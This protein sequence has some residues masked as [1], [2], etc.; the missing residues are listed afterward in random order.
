M[1]AEEIKNAISENP[2]LKKEVL[3][4]FSDTHVIKSIADHDE[5]KENFEKETISK[6]TRKIA[7]HFEADITGYGFEKIEGEKYYDYN[8][9]ALSTLSEK[10]KRSKELEAQIEELK[11]KDVSED[12]KREH[13]DLKALFDKTQLDHE[14][15]KKKLISG[16]NSER[17]EGTIASAMNSLSF[18]SDMPEDVISALKE[19]R[20]EEL[21]GM[22]S[23]FS[24]EGLVFL[25]EDGETMRHPETLKPIT[26]ADLLNDSLASILKK[27]DP[28]RKGIGTKAPKA[29]EGSMVA[30]AGVKTKVQ[31]S[32]HLAEQ[33]LVA[34]TKEYS[35]AFSE[36]GKGLPLR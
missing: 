28:A 8:K 21:M 2:D 7:D 10:A 32:A 1:T 36:M 5:W 26:A 23:S 19:K 11:T 22:N 33:G 9:R 17:K 24:S 25:K 3:G 35:L 20:T 27:S 12:L 29:E 15:D 30:P 4:T 14:E 16:F 34:N 6:K 18:N 13:K 31:L